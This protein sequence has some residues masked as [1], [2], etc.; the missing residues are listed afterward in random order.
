MSVTADARIASDIVVFPAPMRARDTGMAATFRV[1]TSR[2]EVELFP[3]E[4]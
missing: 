2:S 3:P 1:A 4:E